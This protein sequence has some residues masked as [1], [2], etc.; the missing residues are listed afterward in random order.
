MR[1][2]RRWF[3]L[4]KGDWS[5]RKP[6]PFGIA[7][8]PAVSYRG[9]ILVFGGY[10]KSPNDVKNHVLEFT[11]TRDVWS[12]RSPMRE[13]RW[14]GAA[15]LYGDYVYVFGGMGTGN[16]SEAVE[17]YDIAGDAWTTLGSFPRSLRSQGLMTVTVGSKIYIFSEAFTFEYDPVNN[18][19]ARRANAPLARR[20]ATCAHVKAGTEDRIHIIGGFDSAVS[21]AT[22]ANHCYLPASDTW[23]GPRLSAP[24]RAYGVTRDNPVWKNKIYF[25]FGHR[26]PDLFY[27]D[28]YAFDPENDNW[29]NPLGKAF[30]ERDGVACAVADGSLYVIGGRSEPNDA[31]AFGLTHNERLEL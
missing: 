21:D 24:Y 18:L 16:L 28:I 11:P 5:N 23:I 10:G 4:L 7:D 9:R 2:C 19:Y 8:A 27:S 15:A 22:D 25:G 13:P 6:L 20:W 31:T 12:V 30:F 14:G 3:R 1:H 17:R 26:N 29:S